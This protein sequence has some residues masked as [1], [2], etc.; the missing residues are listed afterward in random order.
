[1]VGVMLVTIDTGYVRP[2]AAAVYLRVEGREAAFVETNTAHALP[3]LL[4][5]LEAHGLSPA[6]VR[7]VIVTHAHLDHA[8]GAS[9]VLAAC[10]NA[11][12]VC[13][14]RAK[15]NLVDPTRLVASAVR[16][17]GAQAFDRLYGRLEP[18]AAERVH[19]LA[20]GEALWLG[21]ARLRC[22][23]T[24]GHAKHHVVVH[25]EGHDTVFT[26]DAFGLVY[27]ALQRAGRFAFPS[28]SP[29]DFDAAEALASVD[30]VLALAPRS[31][32]LTHFGQYED[33]DAIAAQV[34][35]WI[36]LSQDAVEAAV[37][38][39]R[40]EAE[41]WLKG[42]LLAHLEELAGEAGLTLGAEDRELLELDMTLN[43]QGLAF[44]VAK[45]LTPT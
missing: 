40:T 21:Q 18:I 22:F 33:L 10:P 43:A 25:D 31:V 45:R 4:G 7:Y 27:P 32:C 13:H 38:A 44:V 12:L 26:G 23:H 14:P 8:A 41:A 29:I 19:E 5:A 16:V 6:D 28:T 24:A 9:A 30:R 39:G 34:R 37:R 3:R 17:Y 42:T 20:D 36:H 2:L 35:R 1:M 15:R 11:T